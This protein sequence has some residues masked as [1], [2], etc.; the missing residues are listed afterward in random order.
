M[1]EAKRRG[2]FEQRAAEG[3]IKREQDRVRRQLARTKAWR[4]LTPEARAV[5]VLALTIGSEDELAELTER[6]L[7]A[8]EPTP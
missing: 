3:K 7:A 2:T 4:M 1:G 5:A 6:K 8:M